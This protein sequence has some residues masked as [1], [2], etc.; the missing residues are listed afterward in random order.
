MQHML[1]VV[2]AIVNVGDSKACINALVIGESRRNN[3]AISGTRCA[4]QQL[5]PWV[6]WWV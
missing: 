2:M 4:L 6:N 3:E 5:K 1:E